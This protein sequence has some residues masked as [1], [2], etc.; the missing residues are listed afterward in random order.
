[1]KSTPL[2]LASKSDPRLVK[3]IN[4]GLLLR[5]LQNQGGLSRAQLAVES[6][7]A[8]STVGLLVKELIEEGWLTEIG[9]AT[10]LGMGRPSTPLD[11]DDF[12][13]GMIG[14]ELSM[15]VMRIVSVSP[16]GRVL[17]TLK[18]P[19]ISTRMGDVC[20]QLARL[21]ASTRMRLKRRGVHL[22]GVGVGLPGAAAGLQRFV[23][24]PDWNTADFV[25]LITHAM[26]QMGLPK[27]PLH[28]QNQASTAALSEYE[29]SEG[30]AKN[31]LIF[32][33]CGTGVGTGIVLN[34]RLFTDVQGASGEVGHSILAMDGPLCLCGRSGCV[35]TFLS[36][37]AL[38]KLP[39]SSMGGQLLGLVLHNIWTTFNPCALVVG[40]P[41]CEKYPD[42]VDVARA[43]L[44]GYAVN[45]GMAAPQLRTPRYGLLASAVGAAAL[46]LHH[47]LRPIYKHVVGHTAVH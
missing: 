18:V 10:T 47:D 42:M 32:V 34:D 14:I 3:R 40:G 44:Q 30:D 46:V 17:S 4:R 23:A 9:T 36:S 35:E 13:R 6:G 39:D 26:A 16:R 12:S 2:V 41:S 22:W 38:S 11:I 31:S 37:Q 7:L 45:A 28:V 5:L 20:L 33:T 8:K 27:M 43:T 25:P 29:F 21:V 15:D 1:M 24:N 19:L